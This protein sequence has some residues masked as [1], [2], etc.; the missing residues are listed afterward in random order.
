VRRETIEYR[1]TVYGADNE[2]VV[3]QK[4]FVTYEEAAGWLQAMLNAGAGAAGR[5]EFNKHTLH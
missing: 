3:E 2:T 1:A 4:D 5:V